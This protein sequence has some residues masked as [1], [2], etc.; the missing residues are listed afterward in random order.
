MLLGVGNAALSAPFVSIIHVKLPQAARTSRD[1]LMRFAAKTP[2]DTRLT[3]TTVTWYGFPRKTSVKLGEL[4]LTKKKIFRLANLEWKPPETP[5]KVQTKFYAK[6]LR[7]R[8]FESIIWE[9]I[10][11]QINNP[12]A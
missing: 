3:F 4:Q 11:S 12:N 10:F 7:R 8:T 2:K 6:T 5:S 9:K 1:A